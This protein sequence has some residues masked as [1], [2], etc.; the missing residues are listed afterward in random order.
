MKRTTS[1]LVFVTGL[2]GLAIAAPPAQAANDDTVAT[3]DS[4]VNAAKSGANYGSSTSLTVDGRDAGTKHVYLKFTVPDVPTGKDLGS[5]DLRL[6][7]SVSAAR[8]VTVYRTGT[9]WAEQTINWSTKPTERV[10]LGSSDALVAGT[11]ETIALDPTLVTPGEVLGVR[12]ETSASKAVQFASTEAGTA[13]FRPSL[14]TSTAAASTPPATTTPPTS[15]TAPATPTNPPATS[16]TPKVIGMS[17]PA[18]TWDQRIQEVGASGVKS[19][20]IFADLSSSGSS[21]LPLIRKAIADGMIPVVSYKV[22][23]PVTMANGGYDAWLATLRTQL[24]GLGA[25][26]TATYWHEPHGD[27]T[28]AVFRAGSQRFLDAVKTPSVSVGPIL[29]GWLLD[30]LNASG[31]ANFAEYTSP[32]LLAAWD[33]VGVDSYQE[34]T[35]SAPNNALLPARAVP[36]LAS[37]LDT[38]GFPDK[39]IVLG[40][41]NGFTGAAI[42]QAGEWILSTPELWIGNVWNVDHTTF[43]VLTGD[44]ITA[45][46]H[47]KADARAM[48]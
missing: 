6:R 4:H 27:M 47:T 10:R 38:Q 21:Q 17:A 8:G 14:R 15:P 40:E 31:R 42:A 35:A 13:S 41:Y 16:T 45:F 23:D 11:T 37:W 34:G 32:E 5:V 20:R 1:A 29:N 7:P 22:P 19:R 48:R 18:N 46:Q 9:G 3:A 26:V 28:P 25:P 33:F 2:T 12:V 30:N 44:R 36:Q 24:S 39:R 43:S